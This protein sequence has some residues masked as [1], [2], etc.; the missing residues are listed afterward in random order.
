MKA[1]EEAKELLGIFYS[2]SDFGIDNDKEIAKMVAE[3]YV[4]D[5]IKQY[6]SIVKHYKQVK[7]LIKK[8]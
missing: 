5:K 8:S 6:Q 4:D 1:K 2:E 3:S 7:Q